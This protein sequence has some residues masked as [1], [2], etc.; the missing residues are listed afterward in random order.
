MQ[1]SPEI[2]KEINERVIFSCIY[3]TKAFWRSYFIIL[4]SSVIL[5]YFDE[6]WEYVVFVAVIMTSLIQ[7]QWVLGGILY[8]RHTV[9]RPQLQCNKFHS[10]FCH[11]YIDLL[12][13]INYVTWYSVIEVTYKSTKIA[14]R[15]WA[16][17]NLIE[18]GV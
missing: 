18:K 8:P 1:S 10:P 11:H 16:V 6:P 15:L 13:Q 5:H 17:F 7:D 4:S 12:K 9:L 3:C 2:I 14:F